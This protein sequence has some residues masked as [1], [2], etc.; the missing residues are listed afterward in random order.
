MRVRTGLL[1]VLLLLVGGMPMHAQ[2]SGAVEVG[3]FGRFTKFESK[4]NFDNRFGVGGRLGVFVLP[5]LAVEG[6]VTYTRTKSQGNLELRHTPVHARL[7]YNVPVEDNAAVLVGAGY[8]R[9]IFRAN[10]RETNSGVGGLLGIRLGLGKLALRLDATGDYIPTAESDAVPPQVAGVQH[11]KSNFHLGGQAGLS[12]LFGANRNGDRDRDGVKD[13][14]DACPDTPAGDAVDARGCSLPKDADRDGV[15]DNLDRCPNTPAGTRVDA[16]GCPVAK[17][18]D[19]DGVVDANDKCPNT[20]AGTAVDASGCPKDSDGDGVADADDRCPNT[21][22]GTAVD[23]TGCPSD[24]DR[25][26]VTDARDVCPNT[27]AGTKVDYFGCALDS[28]GD[29]VSDDKDLCP[30]TV[31]GTS[32]DVKGC[33][34]LFQV[35]KPLILLGVN[36]E[37]GKAVLLPES[38]GVLDQVAQSLIDNPDVNVE[39]AGH[40]DNTGRRAS[41]VRLSQARADAVRDYLIGKG[42]E[43]GRLTAKGYGQEQPMADNATAF[44]RAANRRVELSRT[45]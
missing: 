26:G 10:Y 42:V 43:A 40:T 32:V 34:S 5:N 24:A 28:D 44:G 14:A 19:G 38:Q 36:F 33:T 22:A 13:S 7:I 1:T 35:G 27:P 4:L 30:A 37:T 25:D 23:A 17:D 41:N 20:P 3:A 9:N 11:K 39:V 16:A 12:L 29:G 8:V 15:A 2:K 6:D 31:A 18:A 45:N 21:P